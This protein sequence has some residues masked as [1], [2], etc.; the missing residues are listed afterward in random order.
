[1]KI[2][3]GLLIEVIGKCFQPFLIDLVIAAHFT[4]QQV[5]KCYEKSEMYIF[6]IIFHSKNTIFQL[7]NIGILF[8]HITSKYDHILII[9]SF[10]AVNPKYPGKKN[11]KNGIVLIIPPNML[12]SLKLS[13]IIWITLSS[14]VS[15]FEKSILKRCT[16]EYFSKYSFF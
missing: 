15:F 11:L 1:M 10:W 4:V 12:F 16:W 5:L 8:F 7:I 3:G 14:F 6:E 13:F 2:I 9:L